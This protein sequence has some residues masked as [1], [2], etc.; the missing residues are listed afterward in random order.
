MLDKHM[1][2]ALYAM[3]LDGYTLQSIVSCSGVKA[4]IVKDVLKRFIGVTTVNSTE[5]VKQRV[6]KS[7]LAIEKYND[8]MS[9]LEQSLYYDLRQKIS[10]AVY[11]TG[12]THYLEHRMLPSKSKALVDILIVGDVHYGSVYKDIYN[13]TV[14]HEY[15]SK[16][17]DYILQ[18]CECC[19]N[20]IVIDLGDGIEGDRMHASQ[21]VLIEDVAT[22]QT[23]EYASLFTEFLKKLGLLYDTID[24]YRVPGNH[25]RISKRAG[26]GGLDDMASISSYDWLAGEIIRA[27]LHDEKRVTIVNTGK[28]H[29]SFDIPSGRA[30]ND[31]TG[32]NTPVITVI[33]EHGSCYSTCPTSTTAALQRALLGYTNTLQK[34]PDYYFLGHFHTPYVFDVA[35]TTVIG[36]GGMQ[37]NN[38]YVANSTFKG[39][40]S[41]ALQTFLH[42]KEDSYIY[43]S[44][45]L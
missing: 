45:R 44:I 15:F 12:A 9:V 25:G 19:D 30:S 39:G 40:T 27:Y 41:K 1:E 38:D 33:A 22:V 43:K 32:D 2:D 31:G 21:S 29:L 28:Q 17:Y 13:K 4:E 42:I 18:N 34:K 36:N 23:V 20:L 16:M 24:L 11:K 35:G 7:K 8:D 3:F 26:I 10:D 37:I 6:N 14:V 5:I